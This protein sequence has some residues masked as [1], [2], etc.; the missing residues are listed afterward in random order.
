[1]YNKLLEL[2]NINKKGM[3]SLHYTIIIMFI[4][5]TVNETKS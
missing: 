3:F 4:V 5:T 2:I 1:M